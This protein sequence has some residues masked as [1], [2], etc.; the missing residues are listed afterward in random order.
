MVLSVLENQKLPAWPAA[1][2]MS[3]RV[4]MTKKLLVLAA[5]AWL[6]LA[7]AG[8]LIWPAN[9]LLPSFSTP[10]TNLE[11][12]DVSSSS[13][14][15]INLFTSLEGIVNRTQP[16][17]VCV[18]TANGE[19]EFTWV[20]LHNLPYTTVSG[21]SAIT[22]FQSNITGL[23]VTDTNQPDTLN[24]AT[25]MAGVNN[26]LIC[27]PSL[28]P[29]LT[30]APYNLRVVDD[31]RGRFANK[32]AVYGYLYTNY[33]PLCTHRIIAGLETN[34][35][36][37]LRD[38]LVATK[39]ATVWLDP[40]TSQDAAL[41]GQFVSGMTPANGV[42]IGWWP[43]E[44]NGLTWI[45]TYGIPVLA[46]DYF[47]DAS[48]F[49]G[50]PCPIN[51][52][53]I[54][55][56]PPLQ[57]KVYVSLILSDGDNIQYMQHAMKIN[58]ED[59]NRGVVPIGWTTSSL[60]V[61]MDP[62]MLNYYWST[63]TTND[64]LISGP[65]GAGYT[66]MELWSAANLAAYTSISDGYLQRT[67]LRFI[68]VW[69]N[70]NSAIA[71]SYATNCPSLLGLG[72]Q[73]GTYNAVD[74]GLRTIGLTPTYASTT[75]EML[76]AITSAAASWNGTAPV[77]IMAQA[78]S[79]DLVPADMINIAR[80]YSTNEFVFVRPDHLFMLYNQAYGPPAAATQSAVGIT[81]TG[82]QLQGTAMANA[83]NTMAWLEWGA[84][85]NYGS[86]SAPTNLGNPGKSF[87][88]VTANISGLQPRQIYHYQV[89][90]SNAL[91]ESLGGDKQFTTGGRLEAWGNG[92]GR[93][94]K[95]AARIDECRANQLR[96]FSRIGLEKRWHSRG[97]GGEHERTDQCPG[98][99]EQRH[100]RRG[101]NSAQRG[102]ALEWHCRGMGRK[103]R[104]PN[105]R[106][107]G[108]EQCGRDCGGRLS[109]PGADREQY[110]D[111]VGFQH[112]WAD[113]CARGFKQ[114]RQCGGGLC[115]Q[116]GVAGKRHRDGVG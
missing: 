63:A 69:D 13:F 94:N 51:V 64:C 82:A 42:Y 44:G 11:C 29:T 15:E 85:R 53:P 70:V 5:M 14:A 114:C 113:E 8:G 19:G 104:R 60:S 84:N 65:S 108:V 22:T 12:I 46:S 90:A 20:T 109:H 48:V 55:P 71:K 1:G 9:Q 56:P 40:G 66:H 36:G 10:A 32:Y 57:N 97:L 73:G 103:W 80:S 105:Q 26:E 81:A 43:N 102:A 30:N 77:F 18:T 100:C 23:V 39:C 116:P 67:G 76:S 74:L 25:T 111:R 50:V 7:Q 86:Q 93:R 35:A 89:V 91:G 41:L 88:Q 96:R 59:G 110:G 68:T 112:Q 34:L 16:Q 52:P 38:Y 78:V 115:S 49:S 2:M 4:L 72:D 75:N 62:A 87:V 33:W 83:T 45:A 95:P 24:L 61:N 98:G 27:D 107:R 47:W 21:Y 106:A 99:V 6:N 92:A 31:L 79:W 101:G 37:P 28:L 54:P 3:G 17:I 58:W